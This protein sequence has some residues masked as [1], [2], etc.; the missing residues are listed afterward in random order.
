MRF[1]HLLYIFLSYFLLNTTSAQVEPKYPTDYFRSPIEGRIYLS[2]TFGELRSNHFHAGI[3]IKTAGS[4][5][6]N[7]YAAADGWIS[8]IKISPW[9]YGNAVYME[10][11]NGYTTVYGHL[12]ELKGDVTE[13]I[14]QQQYKKQSFAVDLYLKA[15]QFPVTK[16]DIIAL[17]G[18]SGGSGGPHLHFEIRETANQEPINPLLFGIEVK[19]Y[20]TPTIQ[21][22]RIF[23]AEEGA[24]VQGK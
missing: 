12:K 2:G 9:G 22:I 21:S 6:K 1:S 5:G 16:G 3:D 7:I 14:K 18:N 20:I 19:D 23:P 13:Y 8:R 24:L 10:H 15:N 4:V 11:P 17:S